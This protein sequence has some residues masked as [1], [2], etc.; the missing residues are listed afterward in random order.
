[1][2]ES[3]FF[4]SWKHILINSGH[5]ASQKCQRVGAPS[6]CLLDAHGFKMSA[7]SIHWG[8]TSNLV[9]GKYN[10][11]VGCSGT[12]LKNHLSRVVSSG[13]YNIIRTCP[14]ACWRCA[15]CLRRTDGELSVSFLFDAR[16]SVKRIQGSGWG[17]G[18]VYIWRRTAC[19]HVQHIR[20]THHEIYI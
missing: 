20:C 18:R 17:D 12:T 8:G 4:K 3:L 16:S 19:A 10:R 13:A 11:F 6:L 1:M 5:L 7:P 2:D 9:N 14:W 15:S